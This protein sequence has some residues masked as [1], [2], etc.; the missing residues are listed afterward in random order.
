MDLPELPGRPAP[1]GSDPAGSIPLDSGAPRPRI[2]LPDR[3]DA[4]PEAHPSQPGAPEGHGAPGVH[5]NAPVP[6]RPTGAADT[7]VPAG[8]GAHPASEPPPPFPSA[9]RDSNPASEI[10]AQ[11]E[12][13]ETPAPTPLP[14]GDLFGEEEPQ[15]VEVGELFDEGELP[16][17]AD[18]EAVARSLGET[19]VSPRHQLE[20]WL[21]IMVQMEAS[22]LI[23]RAG[24]RPSCRVNGKIQFLA[25]R[26]PNSGPLLEVLT[27]ICGDDRMQAWRDE[28]SVDI[29]LHMDGLGR[30]RLN[31]YR[32]MGEPALVLRRISNKTPAL[33]SLNL[34]SLALKKLV[35]RERGLFL[36]TG[37]AGS[38]KSTTLAAMIQ[39]LND[40]EERH[41]ITLE[42]PVENIF[43]ENR[44]VISQREV[45]TDCPDF[46]GGLRHALRQSPDLILIGEM[47]DA[48]TVSAALDATETGHM[49]MS[50]LHTV[51]A[52]QTL[53]RILGFFSSEQHKQV[54]MRLAENLAG[55]LSMRLLPTRGG[56]A[57]V[58]ACELMQTTPQVRELLGE[59]KTAEISRVIEQ[60]V[61][62][63]Q[64]SFNMSLRRLVEK[65]LIE[66]DAALTASDRPDEL[67]MAL[68][69]ISGGDSRRRRA[70]GPKGTAQPQAR[71]HGGL[72]MAGEGE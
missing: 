13:D 8:A 59:G 31:A 44:C 19:S 22:D 45:G 53:D 5:P 72:R 57:M 12:P 1:Q 42:D 63:G 10:M 17:P 54:C 51:N 6:S 14:D 16:E 26:V 34:P 4:Q 9:Q 50:T 49:V 23:L 66:L 68:R 71:P 47:R 30:F 43:E 39:H 27:G 58:P 25:G 41:I 56:Q 65:G 28:G 64:I 52:P 24:G 21:A 61:E 55:V 67:L 70:M 20:A 38:G 11:P 7:G 46:Q 62:P 29:A 2:I 18:L 36:V 69:G 37:V 60:G 32:Q 35:K 48:E 40:E 15:A 3:P 33:D